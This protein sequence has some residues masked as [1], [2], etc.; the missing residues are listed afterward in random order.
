MNFGADAQPP[1]EAEVD[2]L[3]EVLERGLTNALSIL[4]PE[5]IDLIAGQGAARWARTPLYQLVCVSHAGHA[6]P[7][8]I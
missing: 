5:R 3:S 4:G 8:W 6:E 2:T 7:P 1:I